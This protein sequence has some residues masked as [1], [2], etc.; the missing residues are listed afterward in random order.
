MRR[1][2]IRRFIQNPDQPLVPE[3]RAAYGKL[4]GAA[5]LVANLLLFLAKVLAGVISGSLSMIADAFN[6]L[7]DAGSSVVTLIGFKLSSAPPDKEH[8]FGHGRMEYLSTMLVAAIIM[9]AGFEL[10]TASI[11]KILHPS[12]PTFSWIS[13]TILVVSIGGKLWM[14]LFYRHI[15]ELIRSDTLKASMTDSRNDVICTSIVLVGSIVAETWGIA[16]DGYIGMAIAL[17]VLWSGFDVM[18]QTV[19]MLI[20]QAPDPELVDGIK[21][22]VL[23]FEGVVGIHDMMIHNYGPGRCIVSLHA[24]VPSREDIVKS[25]DIIDRI[26]QTLLQEYRVIS[27]IHMDPIDTDDERVGDL[28]MLATT[29]LQD[30]DETLQLHDFRVVFGETHTNL[31][32]DVTVPFG[33]QESAMLCTEIQRRIQMVDERLC[34]VI[35]VEHSYI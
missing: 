34:T 3:T 10:A 4:A 7:S 14:A 20:G 35:T 11:D 22:T 12:L 25:H 9:L 15:G 27:C 19:S 33:Y 13:T 24:E 32:F 21:T 30:V 28:R 18:R 31:L 23:S 5:G 8:P 26:E 1:F 17:F 16:V 6:N 2:L 29:V